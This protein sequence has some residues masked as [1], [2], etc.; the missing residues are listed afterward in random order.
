MN[1]VQQAA[2]RV[3]NITA[4]DTSLKDVTLYGIFVASA[5]STPTIKVED[6]NHGTIV[7]T[8]TPTAGAWYTIPFV[9]GGAVTITISGTVDCS[10]FYD[11]K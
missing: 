4:T 8:F 11:L 1:R 2:S 10:V 9:C 5:S 7:N 6:A 3:L